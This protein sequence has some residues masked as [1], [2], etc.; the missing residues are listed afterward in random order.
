MSGISLWSEQERRNN[1]LTATWRVHS[2]GFLF[3]MPFTL[4]VGCDLFAEH[5]A[6]QTHHEVRITSQRP[7]SDWH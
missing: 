6:C 2:V 5:L 4:G 3:L 7:H 1:S